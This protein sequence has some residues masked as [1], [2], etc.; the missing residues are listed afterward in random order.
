VFF[1]LRNY[2]F[3]EVAYDTQLGSKL[4]FAENVRP[5][6]GRVYL[7]SDDSNFLNL[8]NHLHRPN[9]CQVPFFLF[10]N[11][12]FHKVTQDTQVSSKLYF[13]ENVKPI[14]GRVYLSSDD[15]NVLNLF[16]HLHGPNDHQVPFLLF[17]NLQEF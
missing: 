12:K 4:Y 16:N 10:K 17:N 9:D 15:S 5:V 1:F 3:H 8:F 11:Y 2:K 13:A 14:K 6:K 7:S